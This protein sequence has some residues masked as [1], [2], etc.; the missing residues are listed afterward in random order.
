MFHCYPVWV[1]S[2]SGT[3]T[4]LQSSVLLKAGF[5]H[6][7]F[8]RNGGISDGPFRSLNLAS[9]TGDA[10][11]NV[12]ANRRV[13]EQ[14]LGLAADKLYFLSQVHGV[15]AV[16]MLGAESFEQVVRVEGDATLTGVA[17]IGC[18]VRSADCGTILLGDERSGRVAAIHAGWR[19]VVLGVI[20]AATA[21]LRGNRP[22]KL[23]AAVGPHIQRCC[24]EV[25]EDVA[26][27]LA[28]CSSLGQSIV[29][30]SR[31][32]PHV[33]LRRL[34]RSKLEALNVELIED[35]GGCTVC[36]PSLYFSFRRDGQASG[37]LLSAIVARTG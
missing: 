29:D 32:R 24:F 11:A 15:H 33:D 8:T 35:V 26:A 20:E 21:A 6:G 13:A 16:E 31:A 17:D 7:F 12:T 30:R 3:P 1:Q 23:I 14:A 4:I 27:Q 10:L 37:R 5:R 22:A 28:A 2:D 36:E 19:G 9:N 18:G 25:G 34:M